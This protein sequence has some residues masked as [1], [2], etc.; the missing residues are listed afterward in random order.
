M[1]AQVIR[2]FHTAVDPADLDEAR[3][4]F[5]D[6]VLPVFRDMPGCLSMELAMTK[7][8]HPG[9]LLECTAMSR[10]ASGAAM[11]AAMSSR[12]ARE[13]QV[14]IFELLRQEPI[15]RVFEVLS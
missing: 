5:S 7:E 10:W 2:M 12:A 14:R 15:I 11:E 4:L 1:S 6:D 8:H 3:R 13:A 9:G